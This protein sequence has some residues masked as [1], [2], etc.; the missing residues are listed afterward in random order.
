MLQGCSFA[1]ET[2]ERQWGCGGNMPGQND[3]MLSEV[4]RTELETFRSSLLIDMEKLIV[5]SVMLQSGSAL[6]GLP[7][8][9]WG[10][11][12]DVDGEANEFSTVGDVDVLREA[13][14]NAAEM[15]AELE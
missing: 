1:P 11:A 2:K 14:E 9:S 7:I 6:Q 5:R 4:V 15:V 12:K 8:D 13:E 10:Q 3:E